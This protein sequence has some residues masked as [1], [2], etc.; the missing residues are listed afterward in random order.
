MAT[1]AVG[2]IQGCHEPLRCLLQQVDFCCRRDLLLSV[3]DLVN[4]GPQSLEV[5][6][7]FYH[8]QNC[9]RIVLGNHDIHLLAVA[10]GVRQ[11]ESGDTLEAI[12]CAP[13]REVLLDWLRRQPLI[14]RHRDWL[15]VHAGLP[16]QWDAD[17]ALRLG[18]EVQAAL[19]GE[20]W[21]AVLAELFHEDPQPPIWR[22]ELRN[23]LRIRTIVDYLTRMRIC[24]AEGRLNLHYT[25]GGERLPAGMQPWFAHPH[26]RSRRERILFGHWAALR[27]RPQGDH[28]FALD[29]G[30]VWGAQLRLLRLDDLRIFECDCDQQHIQHNGSKH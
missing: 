3:G 26:R 16:P 12:L 30:C 22:E 6:R 28:L 18:G 29:T 11:A 4:R 9:T 1:Y 10:G 24:S 19:G 23:G 27:G 13:D 7:F 17:T 20:D 8:R 14:H 15:L 25:L 5:L 21:R 2:D